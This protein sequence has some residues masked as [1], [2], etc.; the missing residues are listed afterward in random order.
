M[1]LG[2][3]NDLDPKFQRWMLPGGIG[4]FLLWAIATPEGMPF[5]EFLHQRGPT[6]VFV[7]VM[8]G[9]LFAFIINKWRILQREKKAYLA[10]DLSIAQAIRS[11]DLTALTTQA[12]RSASLVGKRLLRMLDVWRSTGSSFQL[13]RSADS[14]VELYELS[15]QSS[16]SL[17]KVLLWAIPLLGFIGT[18]IGMSSAVGSFDAVL[19]NADNVD[20][21][22]NGLTKVTSGLGTAFDTTYLALVVSVIFTFPLN[23]CERLEDRLLSQ[24][25]G[26]VREAVMALSPSGDGVIPDA[27]DPLGVRSK[28]KAEAIEQLTG[29]ASDDLGALISDAFEKHLPDPSVLVGPAQI[30][31]EQLTQAT[32][33]K[34]TPLTSLVRDSVEGIAEARLSLQDQADVIRGSMDGLSQQLN[35]SLRALEP[36]LN[37][38]ER[39]STGSYT[40][41]ETKDQLQALIELRRSI[42]TLNASVARLAPNRRR[43]WGRS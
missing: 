38:L 3:G 21:L 9:M 18:V 25:D 6:Q 30:Y 12:E 1:S 23:A 40:E 33:E 31:A 16:F 11:G 20:G 7:L 14:D 27:P 32:L 8:G 26:E 24:I 39:L 29:L 5:H 17:P 15:S 19:S 28:N 2:L 37:R 43:W 42:E 41:A 35:Q 10:F 34:L 13:E 36:V 4:G 22:K